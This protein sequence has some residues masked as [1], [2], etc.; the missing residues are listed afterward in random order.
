MSF[1]SNLTARK[2]NP[3]E[4]YDRLMCTVAGCKR[5][6]TVDMGRPMCSQHQWSDQ[7]PATMRDIANLLPSEPKTVEQWWDKDAF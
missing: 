1:K 6:W 4:E 7:K 2:E 3:Q 5:R